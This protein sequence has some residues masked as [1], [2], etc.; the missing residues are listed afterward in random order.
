MMALTAE[1]AAAARA[2]SG[3]A[4]SKINNA[5]RFGEDMDD[6]IRAT[7]RHL[8]SAIRKSRT[9]RK[10]VVY[11]GVDEEYAGVLERRK[12]RAGEPVT[13]AAFLSTST[14]EDVARQFLG[15]EGGGM[16]LK[17]HVPP[18]SNALEMHPYSQHPE[19]HEILLPRDAILRVIGYDAN[20]DML[21][22][23]VAAK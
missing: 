22:L 19:E 11:R 9:D 13:D 7:I 10:L 12:L 21:E 16:V 14:R 15:W 20:A 18:G 3:A 6:E 23:E 2:Y 17:I 5:L 1:E 4:Y 8:N